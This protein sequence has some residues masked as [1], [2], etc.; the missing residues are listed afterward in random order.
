MEQCIHSSFIADGKLISSCDFIPAHFEGYEYVYEVV[1]IIDSKPLFFAGHIARLEMSCLLAGF[2][3]PGAEK[4]KRLFKALIEAN[5][6]EAG[7]VKV[8]ATNE[9]N[10]RF[11]LA[12]WFIPAFYPDNEMLTQG[13]EVAL[14][15]LKRTD[16]QIKIHRNEYKQ[17]VAE[18][19][20]QQQVY[21]LLLLDDGR[22]TE[23]SRSN[24]FFI[25]GETLF[26]APDKVVLKGVTR[27]K[28]LEIITRLGLECHK[29]QIHQN[30]L[31][32]Y[33]A[34]FLCGT[35]P[36]V[37]PIARIKELSEFQANHP[38]L[39]QIQQS[40]ENI[41]NDNIGQFVW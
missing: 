17:L 26:T 9:E 29:V 4:L 15:D 12:I 7:N 35:S 1:R 14:I 21:E 2:S 31:Q 19:V 39:L 36:G 11:R 34:A 28:I 32:Q 8:M 6:V 41:R 13:V 16:P 37:L 10:A 23:G 18:S 25:K 5:G 40:Y 24:V 27:D 38:V 22:I 20:K 3:P 33:D 30:E